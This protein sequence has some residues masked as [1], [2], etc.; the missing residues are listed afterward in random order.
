M[1]PRARTLVAASLVFLTLWV[2]VGLA[3]TNGVAVS[4]TVTIE[5][6]SGPS[7][8]VVTNGGEL[9]LDG[10]DGATAVELDHTNG[11]M[12]LSSDA[13]TQATVDSSELEG[14]TSRVTA[15]DATGADLTLD[16]ADKSAVTVGG[17]MSSIEWQDA[18]VD[19]GTVDVTYSASATASLTLRT[20]PA[21]QTVIA[22][23]ADDGTVL[24]QA[25]TD[26]SG[27]GTFSTLDSGT[28]DV[29]IRTTSAP[30]V[31]DATPSGGTIVSASP[32]ELELNISDA[33][34]GASQGDSVSVEFRDAANDSVIGSD[35]V[36][37]PGV[38]TV[39]TGDVTGGLN[40]WYAV[41]TD[42][43]GNEI[44]TQTF[45]YNAPSEL[46]IFQETQPSQLIGD[47]TPVRV[48][49][50][51]DGEERV[52]ERTTTDGT[53]ELEDL[54]VEQ[55][56]VVT[57][58]ANTTEYTY[59]RII[60]DSL[61]EQQNAYLLNQTEPSSDIV[62]QLDDPT[63]EFPPTETV[64]YVEKPI[65]KDWN[66]D[67]NETTRY[68]TIAG[69]VFG[70]SAQFPMTLRTASRY[71]LRVEKTDGSASR[72]LGSYSVAGD[73][74]EPLQIQRVDL[75]ASPDPGYALSAALEGEAPNQRV[76]VRFDDLNGSATVE[77]RVVNASSGDVIV[78]NTTR[79]AA[80]WA[81]I[82]PV[83]TNP[84][85]QAAY[86]VDYTVTRGGQTTTGQTF[87]GQIGGIA[88]RFPG[89]DRILQWA[90]WVAILASMGLMVIVNTRVAPIVGVGMATLLTMLGTI[91]ISSILLGVGG[92]IAV[93]VIIGGS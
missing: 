86:R 35:S 23:D 65:S 38:A 10:S 12:R 71:R 63:G 55:R 22:V 36:S 11:E 47:G 16:P 75:R 15:I 20:L 42:A 64:L 5:A 70:A 27:V 13:E 9:S 92:G 66:G 33:D 84:E 14:T 17:S 19:D 58:R 43:Y 90:S 74:V 21:S 61:I 45:E 49:F 48:R 62:F 40:R 57:V 51:V 4:G 39:E 41:V 81:D 3:L 34:F 73:A 52:I 54:P 8:D 7:V 37:S 50:F 68:Q 46:R 24:G 80:T 78:N 29:V 87:A 32:V 28:H 59:R 60:V 83:S 77:Y 82:H 79:T 26:S 85:Q 76:A 93:L 30:S 69:D 91:S 72:T 44:Q 56:F 31:S 1:R 89:G 53:I 18:V 25:T 67:G 88:H 2:G 6:D